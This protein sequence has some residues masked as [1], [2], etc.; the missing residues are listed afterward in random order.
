MSFVSD[1]SDFL[2]LLDMIICLA[3][4][5]GVGVCWISLEMRRWDF[6]FVG[7][8]IFTLWGGNRS[9][10]CS[11]GVGLVWDDALQAFGCREWPLRS[12]WG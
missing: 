10:V 11:K 9:S 6:R 3:F 12:V 8:L 2:V 4:L 5:I 7:I 1:F